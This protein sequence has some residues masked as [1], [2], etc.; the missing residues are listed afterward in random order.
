MSKTII[1][2]NKGVIKEKLQYYVNCYLCLKLLALLSFFC[3]V[4]RKGN[5]PSA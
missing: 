3:A 4:E 1:Q 5:V 2:L